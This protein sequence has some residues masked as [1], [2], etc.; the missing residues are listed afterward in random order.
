MENLYDY[1]ISC[2]N[3]ILEIVEFFSINNVPKSEQN[4]ISPRRI[5]D[6][7][8]HYN[9]KY[10]S[11]KPPQPRIL[12]KI[13]DKLCEMNFLIAVGKGFSELDNTY[14]RTVDDKWSFK[15][16]EERKIAIQKYECAVFGFPYI[17]NR[18]RSLVVPIVYYDKKGD[19]TIGTGFRWLNG[20][21]T[22]KHCLDGAK[23][24]A[25]S[26]IA[27][28]QLE[29]APIYISENP[30]MDI[31]FIELKLE[32]SKILENMMLWNDGVPEVM[33][34]VITMGYPKIPG[35]THFQTVEKATISAI[36]EKRFTATVGEVAAIAEEIWMKENV[37]LITAKI[38]GG[39]SG[40]PVINKYGEVIGIV[41]EIPFAEGSYDDLGYGT[42]IPIKFLSEIISS[43]SKSLS[44]VKFVD[45]E[46]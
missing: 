25:I 24:I 18:F 13:C 5:I 30:N 36:P 45:Y 28:E 3:L 37:F 42:A 31:A 7:M 38:K 1:S 15:K 26:G 2:P 8:S 32:W 21:A 35:F 23:Q 9:M 22:A 27:K 12:T 34:E 19:I 16:T 44:G 39:N 33:E 43:P 20:I 11:T 10:A 6:F 14:L 41:S 4:V 40:G 17:Y 46:G 29:T